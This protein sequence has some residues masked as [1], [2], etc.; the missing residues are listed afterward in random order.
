MDL[1]LHVRSEEVT[2]NT[3]N[4]RKTTLKKAEQVMDDRTPDE[5]EKY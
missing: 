3:I 4:R 5:E 2:I 1:R